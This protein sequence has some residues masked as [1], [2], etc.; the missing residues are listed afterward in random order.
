M[1][2]VRQTCMKMLEKRGYNV[3]QEHVS[4]SSD[5][6]FDLYGADPIR[7]D[8]TL[9]VEKVRGGQEATLLMLVELTSVGD[10][11]LLLSFHKRHLLRVKQL[12]TA[13]GVLHLCSLQQYV[14]ISQ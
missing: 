13:V 5:A 3:L 6:F 10:Y 7:E 9:L 12:Y 2:R 8:L 11:M 14:Q 1:Y 4:M